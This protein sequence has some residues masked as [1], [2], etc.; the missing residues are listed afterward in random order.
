[1]VVRFVGIDNHCLTFQF[2]VLS[3]QNISCL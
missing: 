2:I 1:M 3:S